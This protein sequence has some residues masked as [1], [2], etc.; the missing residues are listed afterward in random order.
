MWICR[1]QSCCAIKLPLII[2][3]RKTKGYEFYSVTYRLFKIDGLEQIEDYGQA[4][5]YQGSIQG[6]PILGVDDHHEYQ[7]KIS[8]V[9][10]NTWKMLN[11]TRFGEHFQFLVIL[12]LIMVSSQIVEVILL[13]IVKIKLILL[14]VVVVMLVTMV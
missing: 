14:V 5:I 1:S 12:I 10:G 13:V 7:R 3:I 9:C 6:H 11:E 4:V 2:R 8:L